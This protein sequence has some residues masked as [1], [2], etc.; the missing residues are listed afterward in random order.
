MY[1]NNKEYR[2][3]VRDFCKMNC[4]DK[5]IELN[6]DDESRDE[7]LFD[8]LGSQ[9]TMDFIYEKTRDNQ[10]WQNIYDKAAA[11]MLSE[12]REIGLSILFCYDFFWD[13]KECWGSFC[14]SLDGKSLEKF[15]EKNE[16]YKSLKIKL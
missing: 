13:F 3:A 12:N 9:K 14:K 15:D 5:N 1:T 7:L 2:Q 16:F 11:K 8:I 6:I 10:L 4:Q